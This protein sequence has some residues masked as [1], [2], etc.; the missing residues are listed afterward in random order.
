MV[1]AVLFVATL[2]ISCGGSSEDKL[3]DEYSALV[4]D[5]VAQM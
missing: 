2:A 1:S 4:E 3:L 5:A